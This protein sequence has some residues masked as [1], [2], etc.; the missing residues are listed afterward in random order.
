[1]RLT[2]YHSRRIH[3]AIIDIIVEQDAWH[4]RPCA[5]ASEG[6]S[7]NFNQIGNCSLR[8][9]EKFF[10]G[11][12]N[13]TRA[14]KADGAVMKQ[15]EKRDLTRDILERLESESTF[16]SNDVYGDVPQAELGG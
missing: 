2:Q 7:T 3:E 1:M 8:C 10:D 16:N 14:T 12:A 6:E 13:V 9:N 4:S 5:G 11:L 15:D